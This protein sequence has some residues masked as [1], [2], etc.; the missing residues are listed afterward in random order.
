MQ[1]ILIIK[2]N[3]TGAAIFENIAGQFVVKFVE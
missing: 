3:K 2:Y 1:W